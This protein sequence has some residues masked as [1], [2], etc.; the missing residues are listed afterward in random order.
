MKQVLRV[1]VLGPLVLIAL[2]AFWAVSP[3]AALVDWL[4]SDDR[5][6]DYYSFFAFLREITREYL[7]LV[8]NGS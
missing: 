7:S 3:F 8:W 6:S 4:I 5:D 1:L 2:A